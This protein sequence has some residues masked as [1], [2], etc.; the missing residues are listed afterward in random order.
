M[1]TESDSINLS[2]TDMYEKKSVFLR[3]HLVKIARKENI[4][5]LCKRKMI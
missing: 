1:Q 2:I 4:A 3:I 5:T